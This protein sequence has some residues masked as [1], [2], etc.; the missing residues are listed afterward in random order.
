MTRLQGVE[1]LTDTLLFTATVTA[2]CV[3]VT[4]QLRASRSLFLVTLDVCCLSGCL[5]VLGDTAVYKDGVYW[6][7]GR[8]S[9]DIIKSGGYKI[10]AL[11]VERQLLAH[12]D[13]TGEE[14]STHG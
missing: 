3:S 8:T 4:S 13:I 7:M 11:D 6:I 5:P 10:S 14:K 12:P 2:V 9:V 1:P